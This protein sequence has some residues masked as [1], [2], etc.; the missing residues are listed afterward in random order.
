M[1]SFRTTTKATLFASATLKTGTSTACVVASATATAIANA[2]LITPASQSMSAQ[3]P[4]AGRSSSDASAVAALHKRICGMNNVRGMHG[5]CAVSG[6][7]PT[8][9]NLA[10][11]Q[12]LLEKQMAM[13]QSMMVDRTPS[14][15]GK[16]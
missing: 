9:A 5:I 2:A 11:R 3:T 13:M 7:K 10:N 6:K 16:Q 12:E 1:T 14:A 4:P 15:S 8:A